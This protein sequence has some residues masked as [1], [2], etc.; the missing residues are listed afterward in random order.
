M[1][2]RAVL[3][4]I[5][6]SLCCGTNLLAAPGGRLGTLPIG[7]YRCELPGD[8]TG[9]G[10][11]PVPDENFAIRNASS[12]ANAVGSGSYLLT[13]ETVVMTSG[14]KRGA[15]YRRLSDNFLRKLDK[16]G[17]ETRLRCV[18]RSSVRD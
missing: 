5:A 4:L 3:P 10:G 15:Q 11:H 12:Y 17:Q 14:P 18:R 7:E 13:G 16:T 1:I 6:A 8:A 9:L 2:H